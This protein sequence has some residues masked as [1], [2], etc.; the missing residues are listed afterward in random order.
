MH[1][2]ILSLLLFL[3]LHSSAQ[4]VKSINSEGLQRFIQ[5]CDH[6][7]VVA[8]WATWCKPCLNEIPWLQEAVR[9]DSTGAIELVLVSMD[10]P[11]SYPKKLQQF[12][13]NKGYKA[14]LFWLSYPVPGSFFDAIH[15]RWDGAMPSSL[16]INNAI[17]YRNFYGRQLTPL[18]IEKEIKSLTKKN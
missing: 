17:G 9:K 10:L 12:I 4:E 3:S 2:T 1:K 8:F 5:E 14:T 6:P 11:T 7:V 18:Q 15:A 16:W 13:A